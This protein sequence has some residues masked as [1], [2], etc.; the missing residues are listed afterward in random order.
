MVDSKVFRQRQLILI[1]PQWMATLEQGSHFQ[2]GEV[3]QV[4]PKF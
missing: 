4:L 3:E 1:T 2:E